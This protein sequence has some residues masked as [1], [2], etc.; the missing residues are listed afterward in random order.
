MRH[1]SFLVQCNSTHSITHLLLAFGGAL[2]RRGRVKKSSIS[3][4]WAAFDRRNF[5]TSEMVRV[6]SPYSHSIFVPQCLIYIV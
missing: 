4:R 3:N 5:V 1:E 2:R 6:S